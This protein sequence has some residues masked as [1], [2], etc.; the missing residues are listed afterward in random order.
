VL[1]AAGQRI[2][3][4]QLGETESTTD[5]THRNSTTLVGFALRREGQ[6]TL[7]CSE[8]ESNLRIHHPTVALVIDKSLGR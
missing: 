6:V 2:A 8:S 1:D 5:S 7:L 4:A 3:S